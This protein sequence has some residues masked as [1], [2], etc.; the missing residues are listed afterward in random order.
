MVMHQHDWVKTG[1]QGVHIDF[2]S[3]TQ[4][5]HELHCYYLKCATCG[6]IGFRRYHSAVVYTWTPKQA[7]WVTA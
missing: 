2:P 5:R 4:G 7:D 1:K 3:A 6:Q